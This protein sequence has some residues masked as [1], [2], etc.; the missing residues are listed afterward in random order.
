MLCR[1]GG[2]TYS[3][4]EWPYYNDGILGQHDHDIYKEHDYFHEE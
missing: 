3:R 4:V 1:Q 2:K